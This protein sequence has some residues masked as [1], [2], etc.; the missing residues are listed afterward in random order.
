MSKKKI[1]HEEHVDE[2]WLIP[3]ADMLTLLLA[4]FIVMFAMGQVDKAKYEKIKEQFNVIFSGGSGIMEKD[5]KRPIPSSS[6][7]PPVI[8]S[9]AAGKTNMEKEDDMMKEIKK[10]LEEKIKSEGFSEKIVLVLNKEGLDISIQDS[11]L[12]AS[13]DAS[14]MDNATPILS[15]LARTLSEI[16]NRVK[17]IGHTD[18]L[19]IKNAKFR[20]NWDLSA[21][22]AI[23]VMQY[24]VDKGNLNQNRFMIQ[25][26]G[27]HSPLYSNET[28]DGRAKNR[29]VEIIIIRNY[30]ADG[31]SS[32]TP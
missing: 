25:G 1:H 14:V 9:N 16:D 4:L 18:N 31:N 23:N 30:S 3:Y 20:S 11:V 5:G 29:R 10:L 28:K 27:E 7:S 24:L 6:S 21:I 13:G 8:S 2:T 19:P 32:T 22:R 12:F 26:N 17:V 15:M